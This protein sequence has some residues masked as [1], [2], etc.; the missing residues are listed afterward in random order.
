MTDTLANQ[1]HQPNRPLSGQ[2]QGQLQGQL[3]GPRTQESPRRRAG[4]Q[5]STRLGR[6]V[7]SVGYDAALLPVGVLTMVDGLRGDPKRAGW[8][9][10]RLVMFLRP[11]RRPDTYEPTSRSA[12][13]RTRTL[14]LGLL[15]VVLGA[16]SLFLL[17]MLTLTI[18]RGPF[19]GFVDHGPV[20][21]GTWGGPTRAGAWLVHG[22]L[23]VVAAPVFLLALR[24]MTALHT[25]L[26]RPLYGL[27]RR[28]W[29][30]P[31]SIVVAAGMV[32]F[33]WSWLQQ[34]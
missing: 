12:P 19:W 23:G 10:E 16:A 5:Q 1:Q 34:V 21:P 3:Q 27:A 29:V 32:F 33:F 26:V 7:R 4:N 13:G 25:R 8:R 22:V 6:L 18:V 14:G 9:W 20:G 31:A 2:P 15:T 28:R 17:F 11:A 30:L 24:G